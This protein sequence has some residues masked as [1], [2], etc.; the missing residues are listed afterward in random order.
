[1]TNTVNQLIEQC[2]S[3]EPIPFLETE[4]KK[5]YLVYEDGKYY[6]DIYSLDMEGDESHIESQHISDQLARGAV[7]LNITGSML[8]GDA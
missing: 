1:M 5:H 2:K 7:L 3:G 6:V 4:N 8:D